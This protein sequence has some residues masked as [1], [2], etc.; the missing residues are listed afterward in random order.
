MSSPPT[1][2]RSSSFSSSI[3]LPVKKTGTSAPSE[4]DSPTDNDSEI[5]Q[6]VLDDSATGSS[7]DSVSFGEAVE[8]VTAPGNKQPSTVT[9]MPSFDSSDSDSK[10]K[11]NEI[12][13]RPQG[14]AIEAAVISVKQDDTPDVPA[15]TWTDIDLGGVYV[16][17]ASQSPAP[18]KPLT[19]TEA[20]MRYAVPIVMGTGSVVSL[21]L[22]GIYAA[23]GQDEQAAWALGGTVTGVLLAVAALVF[24]NPQTHV[25]PAAKKR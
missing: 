2:S 21:A 7:P 14:P 20:A 3:V 1:L 5:S 12:K 6:T 22:T 4:D 19:R 15:A 25:A 13:K 9:V 8:A 16:G 24:Q 23:H 18:G 10:G 11:E 17:P